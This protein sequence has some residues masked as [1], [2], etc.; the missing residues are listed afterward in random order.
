MN[1]A[2]NIFPEVLYDTN[3][4]NYR[5]PQFEAYSPEILALSQLRY[6]AISPENQPSDN[7]LSTFSQTWEHQADGKI[8]ENLEEILLR[9]VDDIQSINS[10]Q[11]A[12]VKFSDNPQNI[13]FLKSIAILPVAHYRETRKVGADSRGLYGAA[14]LI[15]RFVNS[16]SNVL[17]GEISEREFEEK[18]KEFK[19]FRFP[20][21]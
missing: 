6:Y 17:S 18:L 13:K 4:A 9:V 20:R 14:M 10:L 7:W 12:K 5:E 3:P 21:I 1:I 15:Y 11:E 8:F 19:L 16:F 2:D